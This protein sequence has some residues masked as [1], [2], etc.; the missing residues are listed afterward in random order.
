VDYNDAQAL[1]KRI[2]RFEDWL[3]QWEGRL[4]HDPR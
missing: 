1:L 2:A 3:P 4:T